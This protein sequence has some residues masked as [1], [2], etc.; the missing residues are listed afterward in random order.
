MF[1]KKGL[2]KNV[3]TG[4]ISIVLLLLL[5]STN[6]V[7]SKDIVYLEQGW[8][9]QQRTAFYETPQGSYLIPLSWYFALEQPENK[10]LFSNP[11]HIKK[12]KYTFADYEYGLGKKIPLGFAVETVNG[13]QDWLGYTCAACHTNDIVYKGTRLRIDGAPTLADFNGF[14]ARLQQSVDATLQDDKKFDR[15]ASRVLVSEDTVLFEALRTELTSYFDSLAAFTARNNSKIN[16]GYARLD[17]FGIIMN[18]VFANDLHFPGNISEPNAPV[19]Y[20]FLWNTSQHDWVQW[21]GSANNPLG[22]NVGEVLGTFGSVNLVDLQKLGESSARG[23]ELIDLENLVKILTPPKWPEKILG[24]LDQ[25]KVA[26][27]RIIYEQF[28][29]NELSCA[30]CHPLRDSA[31]NYPVT[32]AEENMFGVQFVETKMTPLKEIGTDPLMATNFATRIVSTAHLAPYLPPPYTGASELP[33]PALLSIL[34][35]LATQNAIGNIHLLAHAENRGKGAA[36]LTGF[37]EA[38][39][40]ADWAITIDAD[41]QHD[42]ADF[43]RF[44]PLLK[45]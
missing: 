45:V 12:Y 1:Q 26:Q 18:E 11:K 3:S 25:D 37:T 13:S 6:T 21:N 34:V 17:A 19:S 28:R 14:I 44:V 15:F 29:D 30:Y 39:K 22:R 36:L 35:G 33:A 42:P 38:A 31:G 10:K 4:K 16:Y 24:E 40:R 43:L 9:N 7:A 5:I 2:G 20:P 8:N 32:P 23:K 27:G 41:G